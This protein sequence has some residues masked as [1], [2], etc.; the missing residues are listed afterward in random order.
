M[1]GVAVRPGRRCPERQGYDGAVPPTVVLASASPRR[2]VLM[3]SIVDDVIVEV[4]DVDE[5]PFLGEAPTTLVARL[6]ASKADAVRRRIGS[7][8]A[9]PPWIV[10]A[11][12]VVVVDGA[13][14][15]K[16]ANDDEATA[17]LRSLSGRTHLV[18]TGHHVAHGEASLSTVVTTEVTFRTLSVRDVARYVASGEGRDKAGAYGIQE[19]GAG[20]VRN[21]VGCYANVVGLSVHAVV[22]AMREL[23]ADDV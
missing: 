14:L 7:G 22:A 20:L 11:D 23:G 17:M 16:P 8:L 1:V 19:R 13:V 21:V 3:Q 5:T 4:P 2:R 9:G 10:A 18:A 15:G 12:T 6:A